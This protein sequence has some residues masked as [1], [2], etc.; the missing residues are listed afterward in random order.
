MHNHLSFVG[1]C[2][3]NVSRETIASG[4]TWHDALLRHD[5]QSYVLHNMMP[6]STTIY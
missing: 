3:L 5:A 6:F 2:Q 1:R 4:I